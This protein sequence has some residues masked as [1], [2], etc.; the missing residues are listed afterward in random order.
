MYITTLS[1][2]FVDKVVEIARIPLAWLCGFALFI[3]D[4]F[5]AGKPIVYIVVLATIIDLIC[6]IAVAIK[7]K[8]FAKSELMR[9]TVEKLVVYGFALIVFIGIDHVI[10]TKTN[11]TMDITSGFVG[12]IIAMTETWSFLA[13][14]LILFP[15]NPFL[16]MMKKAL[17][18]ELARKLG[19]EEEEVDTILNEYIAAKNKAHKSRKAKKQPRGKNGQFT[20]K[21]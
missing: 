6:G 13:L 3:S 18:G 2:H 1:S 12:A 10:E 14:L 5:T 19:C 17:R 20:K 11:F 9:Q 7:R 15:K 8:N 21:K 16:Q 4:A